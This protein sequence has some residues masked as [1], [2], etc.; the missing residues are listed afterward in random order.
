MR[1]FAFTLMFCVA[2]SAGAATIYKWVDAQGVVHYSDQPH[3]GAEKLELG[4]I[5]TYS[6]TSSRPRDA[7]P[8]GDAPPPSDGPPYA[9][10]E[11]YKP[12]T[13]EVFFNTQSVIAKLRV[14]PALR[15]GD[16]VFLA[17][18]GRRLPDPPSGTEVTVSPVFRGTHTLMLVVEDR[19]GNVVCQSDPVTFHVRQPSTRAPNPAN[20][21]RF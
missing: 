12:S 10:C 14:Q 11:L 15:R 4:E 17:L 8:V 18:N 13:D 3:P 7:A 9:V 2:A 5:Q 19:G 1:A 20:R 21:P 6:G 16:Q